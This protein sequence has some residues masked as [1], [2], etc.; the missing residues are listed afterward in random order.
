VASEYV[1]EIV[2]QAL[3]SSE[4]KRF[5]DHNG[6]DPTATFRAGGKYLAGP[7]VDFRSQGGSTITQ[8]VARN[9]YLEDWLLNQRNPK[10]LLDTLPTRIVAWFWGPVRTNIALRKIREVKYAIR[11]EKSLAKHFERTRPKSRGFRQWIAFDVLGLFDG[12]TQAKER[13]LG[14]YANLVYLGNGV[15]GVSYGARFYFGKDLESLT[16]DEAAFLA[17]LIPLPG[18]YARLDGNGTLHREQVL[19]RNAVLDRMAANGYLDPARLE[20]LKNRPLVLTPPRLK[21]KTEEPAV[22]SAML[23][24]LESLG[25]PQRDVLEGRV[26]VHLTADR[27]IQAVVNAAVL[28]GI[29]GTGS[30]TMPGYAGTFGMRPDATPQSAVVVLRNRDAAIL[31][32]FGGLYDDRPN[33]Y[34]QFNRAIQARRQPGSTFKSVDTL[35][36]VSA[37]LN[38]DSPVYDG[39][40]SYNMGGWYRAVENYD[41]K[42]LGWI[43]LREAIAQSRNVPV[44]RSVI[45]QGGGHTAAIRWA[46]AVGISSPLDPYPSTI[47]GASGVTPLEMTNAFRAIISGRVAK[48][49]LIDA[50]TDHVGNERYRAADASWELALAPEKLTY[51]Q[52]LLRGTVRLPRGTAHSLDT[53]NFPIQVMAKTGTSNE[54]RDAWFIASTY[55]L[56]GITVGVWVGYDDFSL[57][58][59]DRATGAGV[60]LPI[61]REVLLA[62]YGPGGLLGTPPRMPRDIEDRIDAYRLRAYPDTNGMNK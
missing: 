6:W 27:N 29:F 28:D 60:A 21:T 25:I 34:A 43:P 20:W 58:L 56:D 15:Y 55:G 52:E 51:I 1:P 23:G 61:A 37:N 7:L 35:A 10:L 44:L 17:S 5:W 9:L 2:R 4:D 41:R 14:T 13:I 11:L 57:A 30:P 12:R 40:M 38:P 42:Y 45:D 54:H 46:Q 62:L 31:S 16:A 18:K 8:Q 59:A 32:L 49:Y 50:V 24:E 3:V 33:N 47:L 26:R 39:P 53:S 19:R 22:V 48:P 36:L